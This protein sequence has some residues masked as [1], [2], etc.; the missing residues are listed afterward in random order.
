MPRSVMAFKSAADGGFCA[1]VLVHAVPR[2][3]AT[4]KIFRL[5][6]F[7]RKAF[8]SQKAQDDV[9][10]HCPCKLVKGK[11]GRENRRPVL[12]VRS[13]Q[14]HRQSSYFSQQSCILAG[15]A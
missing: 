4:K 12:F 14:L 5:T 13:G 6:N 7:V 3:T 10:S 15:G 9:T 8:R 2:S 11:T 1:D